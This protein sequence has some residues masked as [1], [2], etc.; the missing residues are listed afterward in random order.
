MEIQLSA[1]FPCARAGADFDVTM[2]RL[3]NQ[4]YFQ[5]C[6]VVSMTVLQHH[7]PLISHSL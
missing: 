4:R 5:D 1:Y 6:I 2:G 7:R 3:Q